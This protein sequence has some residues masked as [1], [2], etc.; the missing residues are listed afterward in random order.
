MSVWKLLTESLS[1]PERMA[2]TFVSPSHL[3]LSFL[4]FNNTHGSFLLGKKLL[5]VMDKIGH[6]I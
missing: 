4:N 1:G 2:G 3:P 6:H 5:K